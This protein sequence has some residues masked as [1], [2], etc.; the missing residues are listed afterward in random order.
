MAARI[1]HRAARRASS[2][3][4]RTMTPRPTRRFALA[5]ALAAGCTAACGAPPARSFAVVLAEPQLLDC[6]LVIPDA[7]VDVENAAEIFA[8]IT[9]SWRDRWDAGLLRPAGGRL[10]VVR[11]GDGSLAWFEDLPPG[12][13]SPWNGLVFEGEPHDD[14]VDAALSTGHDS[15]AEACGE[16]L[17]MESALLATIDGGEI[18]G[19]VRR[20]EYTYFASAASGCAAHV[21]C[22]RNIALAG[23]EEE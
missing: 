12:Q 5:A 2:A 16:V 10:H 3:T 8:S 15:H 11:D 6:A 18:D 19:R 23:A 20:T 21:E 22:A 9:T 1:A 4:I 7:G 13:Y 17:D 14:H